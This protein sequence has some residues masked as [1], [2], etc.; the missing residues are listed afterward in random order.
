MFRSVRRP[1]RD[2]G[3]KPRPDHA[4]GFAAR[5]SLS[6]PLSLAALS[7]KAQELR[8]GLKQPPVVLL[9]GFE[10]ALLRSP[11]CAEC[12]HKR[13]V[14][15]AQDDYVRVR[16]VQ[17]VVEL[18]KLLLLYAYSPPNHRRRSLA[19]LLGGVRSSYYFGCCLPQVL[20]ATRPR[21]LSRPLSFT[22]NFGEFTSHALDVCC[23]DWE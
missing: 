7:K 2:G 11:T 22:P 16:L 14:L 3:G 20:M 5:R 1:S 15:T 8:V 9:G 6:A 21:R 4:L 10:Y 13:A 23:V 12:G 19:A 18:G 17:V